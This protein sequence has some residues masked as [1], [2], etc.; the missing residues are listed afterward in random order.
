MMR[1]IPASLS[2]RLLIVFVIT[3]IAAAVL[4]SSLFTRGLG[5]QWQRAIVPHLIQYVAYVRDDLG[6]PINET[7]AR[8]LTSRVPIHIQAHDIS[9]GELLFSTRPTPMNITAIRFSKPGQ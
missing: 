8:E 4:M 3:A 9:T 6:S 2:S 5:S 1:L 7:R